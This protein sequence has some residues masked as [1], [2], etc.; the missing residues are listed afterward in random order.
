MSAGF[1]VDQLRVDADPVYATLHAPFHDVACAELATNLAGI[2]RLTLIRESRVA[3][4]HEGVGDAREIRRQALRDAVD[5]IVLLPVVR[6]MTKGITTTERR[7]TAE[8]EGA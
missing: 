5:E 2:D 4:D 8:G 7:G 6:E 1:G 3:A